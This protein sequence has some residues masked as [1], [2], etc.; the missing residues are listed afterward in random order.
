MIDRALASNDSATP[1][2]GRAWLLT[3]FIAVALSAGARAD[4]KLELQSIAASCAACHGT[5]GHSQA[6]APIPSLAHLPTAYFMAR[7]HAFR[8]DETL[9]TSVM[10]QIAKG[11]DDH[12]L[13][14]L[15][16]YYA[17]QPRS[18]Y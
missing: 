9:S 18:R 3:M 10:A 7:M 13:Q 17:R 2:G 1:R 8:E 6:Q 11:Y 16:E 14:Q 4:E 12:Q 5:D 15:A